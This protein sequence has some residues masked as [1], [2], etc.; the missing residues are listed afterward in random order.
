M[1]ILRAIIQNYLETGEPVGSRTISKY[2]DLNLSSATIRNEMSDLE[3]M[4]YIIQPH[5][6]AGRIPSDKGYRLYVDMLMQD[7]Q[8]EMD[9]LKLELNA[10]SEKLDSILKEAAKVIAVNTNYASMITAPRYRKHRIKFLQLT[11]VDP[12]SLLT[13]I[14]LDGNIVKNNLIHTE[15]ELT[16]ETL[17]KLNLMLNTFLQGLDL[18]EI[19]ASVIQKIRNESGGYSS[20]ISDILDVIATSMESEEIEAYTSGSTNIFKYPELNDSEKA[21]GLLNALEEKK[22]LTELM[23]QEGDSERGIQVY[24]GDESPIEATK[25]CS[26]VTAT[27]HIEEGVYGKIGII[28][29]RRMD[30]EKVVGTLKNLMSELD[31]IFK[32]DK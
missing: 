17:L 6:S 29:P 16:S 1:T 20:L 30:Y 21:S 23:Y 10:K 24:I 31:Q 2:T 26:V 22:Q 8:M 27:Y 4:G 7:K 9:N 3:E 28:G 15:E 14:I 13:V 25:D 32:K 12:E 5:T 19:N 11:Q 18:Q